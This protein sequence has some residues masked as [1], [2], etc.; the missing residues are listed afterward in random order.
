MY[1]QSPTTRPPLAHHSPTTLPPLAHHS[2]TT[3]PPLAHHSPILAYP[4]VPK[5]MTRTRMTSAAMV[6]KVALKRGD[7]VYCRDDHKHYYVQRVLV[8]RAGWVEVMEAMNSRLKEAQFKPIYL[9]MDSLY[10]DVYG[11]P[12]PVRVAV[13]Q[14]GRVKKEAVVDADYNRRKD[15]ANTLFWSR[16]K[17]IVT[18]SSK[19]V[20]ALLLDAPPRGFA[21]KVPNSTDFLMHKQ[22]VRPDNIVVVN[23]CPKIIASLRRLG[24]QAHPT[25]LHDYVADARPDRPFNYLYLDAC[26]SYEKQVRPALHGMLENHTRW[27][28]NETLLNIVVC[29][30]NGKGS[31]DHIRRD[32][33]KW[34]REYAFG[35]VL[36]W[37]MDAEN[38]LMHSTTCLLK[39]V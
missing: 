14:P 32:L 38:P 11:K 2:P 36:F 19:D 5:T 30:R 35:H 16:F 26:G 21:S 33:D 15:V 22:G 17:S 12:R 9:H 37:P 39:R 24:T 28:A 29:K 18:S 31:P 6:Q 1:R 20:H 25:M 27:L 23:P 4:Q 13:R 10:K 3:R 34:C 8:H 7:T